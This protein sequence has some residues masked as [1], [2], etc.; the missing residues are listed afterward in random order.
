MDCFSRLG[1]NLC[2]DPL[3]RDYI[4]Q[5]NALRQKN[6]S[7]SEL[8]MEPENM[9]YFRGPRVN[10]PSH[11][12]AALNPLADASKKHP[13]AL[14]ILDAAQNLKCGLQHLSNWPVSFGLFTSTA[15]ATATGTRSLYNSDLT[16]AASMFAR[17]DWEIYGFNSGHF[18]SSVMERGIQINVVL[19]SNPFANERA[20]FKQFTKCPTI[21]SS[22]PALLDHVPGSG[23]TSKLAGY[24]IHSHS[25]TTSKPTTH[26]WDIQAS[27]VT[28]LRLIWL[29][30]IVLAFVHPDHDSHAVS[31]GFLQRLC[32]DGWVCSDTVVSYPDFGDSVSKSCCLIAAVH[33]NTEPS[34]KPIEFKHRHQRHRVGLG[35]SFGVHSIGPN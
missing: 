30:S 27:I 3:L 20:L 16:A 22:T 8:P 18:V 14:Q 15:R 6:P 11:Y 10:T 13:S 7:L 34:C 9:P 25:Y 33:S 2:Y 26:F 28:Q 32:K 29:L 21:L 23:I 17:F 19:S 24:M 4:E 1:A 12:A 31:N 5:V 35:N